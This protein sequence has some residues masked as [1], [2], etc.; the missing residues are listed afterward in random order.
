M[1]QAPRENLL[2]YNGRSIELRGKFASS[3]GKFFPEQPRYLFACFQIEEKLAYTA[4][5]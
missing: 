2:E 3:Q 1:K 5:K 4:K